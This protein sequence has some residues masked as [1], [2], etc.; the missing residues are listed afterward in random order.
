LHISLDIE[1]TLV[2]IEKPYFEDIDSKYGTKYESKGTGEWYLTDIPE[3]SPQ[4]FVEKTKQ[5]WLN[6]IDRMKPIEEGFEKYIKKIDD[7]HTIDLVT[8]RQGC[9][10]KLKD[11]IEGHGLREGKDYKNFIVTKDKSTFEDKY[12]VFV[13]DKPILDVKNLIVFDRNYNKERTSPIRIFSLGELIP[14]FNKYEDIVR[15][16]MNFG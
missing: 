3:A 9:R 11:W 1:G 14:M 7:R 15:K 10:N 16:M 12:D 2:N 4:D 8:E 13:D 5:I 6:E